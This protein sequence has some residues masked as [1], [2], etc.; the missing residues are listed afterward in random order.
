MALGAAASEGVARMAKPKKPAGWMAPVELLR[1]RGGDADGVEVAKYSDDMGPMELRR[2]ARVETTQIVAKSTLTGKMESRKVR[3]TVDALTIMFRAGSIN[4]AM[5]DAGRKFEA[6]FALAHLDPSRAADIGRLPGGAGGQDADAV[7]RAKDRV[8][9]A[10]R[11]LGGHG[12]PIGQAAW[13]VLGVGLPVGEFARRQRW[14]NGKGAHMRAATA[15]GLV[16]GAL[17]V[18]AGEHAID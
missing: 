6:D 11:R 5:L 1:L 8:W 18:L 3:K 9:R 14:G 10:L 12:T 7:Y 17:S 13:W 16:V 4:R 2:H 15:S